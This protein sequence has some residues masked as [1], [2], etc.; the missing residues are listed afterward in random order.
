M[1]SRDQ[2]RV[3]LIQIREEKDIAKEELDCFAKYSDLNT[4]QFTCLDVFAMPD[5]PPELATDYDAVFVG[6][7]SGTT[8]RDPDTY[9]FVPHCANLLI[10]CME[11]EIPVFASCFG[12]QL[13]VI[14]LGGEIVKDEI[15]Y[16]MGTIP[17]TLTAAAATDPLMCSMP[18]PFIGICVHKEKADWL[19]E[20][21]TLLAKTDLCCHAFR[22]TG[23]PFW[24]FQF[25]PEVDK[26]ILRTRLGAYR[27]MY[28]DN[29]DHY[30]K[31][32]DECLETPEAND[33]C[34]VFVDHLL[35]E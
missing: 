12:F 13:A 2:L 14:A 20:G 24:A 1:K 31:I 19:P 26:E 23:K 17:V 29:D 22:I 27:T 18:N 21:C 4:S 16:E 6:G 28:T 33:L 15:N 9:P 34:R 8:V 3:L 35:A 7:A 5:F 11:K 25:H 32:I 30:Q 10:Y